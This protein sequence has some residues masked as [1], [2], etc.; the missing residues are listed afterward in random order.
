MEDQPLGAKRNGPTL[1]E[2]VESLFNGHKESHLQHEAAHTRE[3]LFAQRAIEAAAELAKENKADANEWRGAMG[4]RER[5]FATKAQ[6]E[7]LLSRM[8][9]L[10]DAEIARVVE[11]KL[12]TIQMAEAKV[13]DDRDRQRQQW[14]I[15]TAIGIVVFLAAQV[16]RLIFPT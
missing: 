11:E 12:T 16:S 15:A 7:G 10:E 14:F 3:H 1:R 9:K 5:N 4:D 13:Q 8:E 2:Y 6:L